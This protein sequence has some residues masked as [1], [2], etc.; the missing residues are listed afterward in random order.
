MSLRVPLRCNFCGAKGH[1]VAEACISNGSVAVWWRCRQ[2]DHRWP[3]LSHVQAEERR[4]G[5]PESPA[6]DSGR[7]PQ[8]RNQ[9]S[10]PGCT[11]PP[12]LHF[13][14]SGGGVMM[15]PWPDSSSAGP[16]V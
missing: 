2:C 12:Q 1:V 6:S 15:V 16:L 3:V 7:P 10:S 14:K 11:G 5:A 13:A 4:H 9:V 8:E